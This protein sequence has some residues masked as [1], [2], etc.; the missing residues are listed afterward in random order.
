MQALNEM[1]LEMH[2]SPPDMFS[3]ILENCKTAFLLES[4]EGPK[5][6]ARFSYLGFL[7]KK[8]IILKNGRLEVDGKERETKNPLLEL[9]KEI[10]V[11]A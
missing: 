4:S 6:L 7:P 1:P 5:K 9:K 11:S 2:I 10:G 8:H 3:A